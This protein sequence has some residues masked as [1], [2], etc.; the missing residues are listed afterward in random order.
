MKRFRC[1]TSFWTLGGGSNPRL[2]EP[3]ACPS[4]G[5]PAARKQAVS[6]LPNVPCKSFKIGKEENGAGGLRVGVGV[7]MGA[8]HRGVCW[9]KR[10]ENG[11]GG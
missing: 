7:D 9:G 5:M 4:D 2:A 6:A 3:P 11:G 1:A 8:G 10:G